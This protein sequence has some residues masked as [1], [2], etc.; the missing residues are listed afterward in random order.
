[1]VPSRIG[2]DLGSYAAQCVVYGPCSGFL[3]NYFQICESDEWV[4]RELMI[5]NDLFHNGAEK[6]QFRHPT[7]NAFALPWLHGIV[8]F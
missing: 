6:G 8:G 5:V 7:R 3:E 1:M 2:Q 4:I